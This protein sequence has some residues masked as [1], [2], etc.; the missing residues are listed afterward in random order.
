[1]ER[2]PRKDPRPGDI[3]LING[4]TVEVVAVGA[5]AFKIEAFEQL[6]AMTPAEWQEY[7]ATAALPRGDGAR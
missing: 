5:V 2:D 4:E 7:A 3:L 1:M 6:G